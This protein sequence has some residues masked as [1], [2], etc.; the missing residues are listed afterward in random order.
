M[1]ACQSPLASIH[2]NNTQRGC[3]SIRSSNA[4]RPRTHLPFW[5]MRISLSFHSIP[6]ALS[7]S[8]KRFKSPHS[9]PTDLR[10]ICIFRDSPKFYAPSQQTWSCAQPTHRAHCFCAQTHANYNVFVEFQKKQ[11]QAHCVSQVYEEKN[12]LHFQ[13]CPRQFGLSKVWFC[14]W[15]PAN[16]KRRKMAWLDVNRIRCCVGSEN[17]KR[18]N[19]KKLCWPTKYGTHFDF[20][21]VCFTISHFRSIICDY[22]NPLDV[23]KLRRVNRQLSRVVTSRLNSLIYF[24]ILRCD[25]AAE[26]VASNPESKL[27]STIFCI[28]EVQK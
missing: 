27:I 25:S 3:L 2:T 28:F 20:N 10:L 18:N 19:L 4:H 26:L 24:D 17:P 8:N 9:K 5:F 11:V 14:S 23:L 6:I 13:K 15:M 1:C 7:S 21:S 12:V 16:A 22:S